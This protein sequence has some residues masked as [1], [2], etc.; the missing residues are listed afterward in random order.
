[1]KQFLPKLIKFKKYSEKSGYLVPF[2]NVKKKIDLGNN[3]PIKIKRIF[4]SSAKKGTF[5]GDHAHK[6]CSQLLLCVD[7][8]IKVETIFKINKKKTY[9]ISKNKNYALLLP[10]LVWSRIHFKNKKSLL[11]VICDYKYDYKREYINSYEEFIN[12]SKKKFN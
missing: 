4:F 1:M 11:V 5:R 3:C 8:S 9:N 10:P 12:I 2:E 7:G 6:K